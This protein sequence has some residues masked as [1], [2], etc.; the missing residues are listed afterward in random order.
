MSKQ[1]FIP[2]T[3]EDFKELLRTILKEESEHFQK[4]SPAGLDEF[5]P[6]AEACKRAHCSKPK[7]YDLFKKGIINRY[8]LDGLVRVNL[9]ELENALKEGKFSGAK[10][11]GDD[12]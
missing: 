9:S 5:V 8:Y 11:G 4:P 1:F 3:L 2:I 6:I 7:M 12:A 10:K